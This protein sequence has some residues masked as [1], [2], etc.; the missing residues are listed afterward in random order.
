MFTPYSV[1]IDQVKSSFCRRHTKYLLIQ[2]PNVYG[3]VFYKLVEL[4]V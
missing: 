3:I 2:E 1:R 4:C